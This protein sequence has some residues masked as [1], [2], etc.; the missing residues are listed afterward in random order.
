[1]YLGFRTCTW[2]RL[3][4]SLRFC[5][6]FS[7]LYPWLSYL[8]VASLDPEIT[9]CKLSAMSH[10]S[11]SCY[12]F[13]VFRNYVANDLTEVKVNTQ[14]LRVKKI[15]VKRTKKNRTINS[16]IITSLLPIGTDSIKPASKKLVKSK[17]L[18]NARSTYAS[19]VT[20][21]VLRMHPKSQSRFSFRLQ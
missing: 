7:C 16:S 8:T 1:M 2:L 18:T 21:P 14:H 5:F 15:M 20:K 13:C 19:Q 17:S 11:H 9:S 10:H 4:L 6:T 12:S 3:G